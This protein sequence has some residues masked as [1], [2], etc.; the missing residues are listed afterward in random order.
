VNF[1]HAEGV[2]A[3]EN[4]AHIKLG[5]EVIQ[6][7]N[8]SVGPWF[9][10]PVEQSLPAIIFAGNLPFP[11]QSAGQFFQASSHKLLESYVNFKT[12]PV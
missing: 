3:S 11:N 5:L 12:D 10:K 1:P 9:G 2:R 8:A 6:D 4:L 7:D